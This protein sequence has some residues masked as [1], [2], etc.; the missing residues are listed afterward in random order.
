[1]SQ[2]GWLGVAS[3]GH[4]LLTVQINAVNS[5]WLG[6]N[7]KGADDFREVLSES[8]P[9]SPFAWLPDRRIVFRSYADGG[10]NFWLMEADG[11]DRRQ[12]TTDAQASDR[13]VCASPD[14]KSVVF[15]SWRGGRQNLWR[16]DVGAGTLAQLT[17]GAGE[18]YPSC[19]PD[20]RWVVYQSGLGIGKPTVWRLSL[21][22]G[23]PE[24]LIETFATKPVLSNDGTRLAYFFMDEVKWR[25]GVIPAGG[26][27]MLQSLDV[28]VSVTERVLRWSPDDDALYYISTIGD[29]GNVWSLP[30]DG[31]PPRPVTTFTSHVLED[32]TFS[33]DRKQLALTRGTTRR[34]VVLLGNVR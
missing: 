26:G 31:A 27:G 30:L 8:G 28:P 20:G 15:P 4:T 34:D 11:T 1:M 25:I 14:G 3:D 16:M 29:V 24:P 13:G 22:G 33:P 17:T 9:L 32:F 6:T 2:Y 12:L 21:G 19:S 7:E 5:V 18:A 10:A 23:I